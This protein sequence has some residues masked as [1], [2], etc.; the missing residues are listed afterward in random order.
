MHSLANVAPEQIAPTEGYLAYLGGKKKVL[1][2]GM[3]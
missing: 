1:I 2:E 3:E